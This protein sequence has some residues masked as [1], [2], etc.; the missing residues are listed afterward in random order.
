MNVK[1]KSAFMVLILLG[2]VILAFS[3]IEERHLV[4]VI[5]PSGVIG[6]HEK[7]LLILST[8]LMLIIVIPVFFLTFMYMWE[9]RAGNKDAEYRPDWDN[10]VFAEI[11][12]WGL[13]MLI[14]FALSVLAWRRTHELDPFKPIESDSKTITIQVVALQWKWLFLY[15]EENI[16]TVN[17]IQIP[18]NVP[19]KFEITSDAPMNSFW[20]PALG[21]QIYAM[22]GMKS[23]L[24]LMADTTGEFRGSSANI[25]GDGFAGMT[26]VTKASSQEEYDQWIKQ[27][28]SSSQAMNVQAYKQL[29]QP[30]SYNPQAFYKLEAPTLFNDIIMKYMVP[31][32]ELAR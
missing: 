14:V 6:V 7:R 29:V 30:S 5:F 21:G 28:Q 20:I 13:P 24:H 17:Y 31:N 1:Q 27:V 16:A 3:V 25:S 2:L 15:P 4:P 8:L 32:H 26:F 19:V 11:V 10:S 9:Y 23:E 18:D 12:W 22:P